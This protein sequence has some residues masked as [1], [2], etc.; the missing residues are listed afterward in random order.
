MAHAREEGVCP[1]E[2]CPTVVS[3]SQV[4]FKHV[5]PLRWDQVLTKEPKSDEWGTYTGTLACVWGQGHGHGR[6]WSPA[7]DTRA[8]QSSVGITYT[9][10]R[11]TG[12]SLT[13]RPTGREAD[14]DRCIKY[15]ETKSSYFCRKDYIYEKKHNL[16]KSNS[17]MM[18][19]KVVTCFICLHIYTYKIHMCV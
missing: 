1:Q 18:K 15:I 17:T 8:R 3:W 10:G 9:K 14:C 11:V 6:G 12:K 16:N 4:K 13:I 19:V 5:C 2:G 7:G